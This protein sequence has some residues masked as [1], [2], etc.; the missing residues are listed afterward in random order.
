ME[1]EDFLIGKDLPRLPIHRLVIEGRGCETR[2]YA[3]CIDFSSV[4]MS[5]IGMTEIGRQGFNMD[6]LHRDDKDGVTVNVTFKESH[7][8][9]RTWPEHGFAILEISSCKEFDT[10]RVTQ[11]FRMFFKP[12]R[13]F[14][15]EVNMVEME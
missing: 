15:G 5:T 8:V 2:S 10:G 1:E 4:L 3:S 13:L 9:F 14:L 12:K 11:A 7:Q 6:N